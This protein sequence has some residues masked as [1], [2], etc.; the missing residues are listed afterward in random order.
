MRD[1]KREELNHLRTTAAASLHALQER[2]GLL[3]EG[4]AEWPSTERDMDTLMRAWRSDSNRDRPPKDTLVEAL[5]FALGYYLTGKFSLRWCI[6]PDDISLS[7]CRVVGEHYG[8]PLCIAPFDLVEHQVESRLQRNFSNLVDE[9]LQA[10]S[11]PI[12]TYSLAS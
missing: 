6:A 12:R 9:A 7:R 1:I 2:Y 4:M 3:R 8:N 11:L 5:G 10:R